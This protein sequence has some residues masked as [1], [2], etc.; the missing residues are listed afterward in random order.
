MKLP[1]I[2]LTLGL[3]VACV[4]LFFAGRWTSPKAT[5]EDHHVADSLVR[6]EHRRTIQLQEIEDSLAYYKYNFLKFKALSELP[7]KEK[8]IHHTIYRNDTTRNN[9][10]SDFELDS[11]ICTRFKK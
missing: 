4:V 5:A 10:Y 6:D 11:L 2:S 7:P 9:T 1:Q 3:C 8:I